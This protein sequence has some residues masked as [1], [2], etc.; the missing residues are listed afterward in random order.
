MNQNPSMHEKIEFLKVLAQNNEFISD[1]TE[2]KVKKAKEL[3]KNNANS[4]FDL[5]RIFASLNLLNAAIKQPKYK[6]LIEYND[7]KGNV[8]R[9]MHYLISLRYNKYDLT[10]YINP[11]SKCAYIEIF[12]LQFSFHNIMFNDKIKS[13][14]ESDKNLVMPWKE[15]RLQRIAGEIFDLSLSLIS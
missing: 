12:S 3:I 11:E 15:I 7:I 13:F 8:S 1:I 2:I 5:F 9:I 6:A 10:F 14:V 4:I